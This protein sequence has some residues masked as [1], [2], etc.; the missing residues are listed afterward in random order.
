[1]RLAQQ[2]RA[3]AGEEIDAALIERLFEPKRA[4]LEWQLAEGELVDNSLRLLSELLLLEP[5][6]IRCRKDAPGLF[7]RAIFEALADARTVTGMGEDDILARWRDKTIPRVL[8]PALRR[9]E[10]SGS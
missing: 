6:A 5:K 4:L 2:V 1:M 9:L 3:Q 8:A 7:T 10:R